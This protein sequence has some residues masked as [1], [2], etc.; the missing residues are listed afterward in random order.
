M[1]RSERHHLKENEISGIVNQTVAQI[2]EHKARFGMVA[3]IVALVAVAG[4]GY[5][6]W[7]TRSETRAHTMFGE[8]LGIFQAP[9]QA[10][11]A[12]T[13]GAT[14]VQA[15][16]TYPTLNARAE[17]VLPKFM[18][19]ADA[20]PSS[21][22]GIAARY[23]AASALS[24]L[25]RGADAAARFKDVEDRAGAD[26]FFGKMARLGTIDAQVL[27][28]Q[29]D[30]AIT[31]AQALVSVTDD[32]YPRDAMLMQLGRIYAAAG[33]T[34]Q[35]KETFNKVLSDFPE[36]LYADEAHQQIDA[37]AKS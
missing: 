13:E 12:P 28:K 4:G 22:S 21:A 30:Q 8:A 10:P 20:Y 33:K 31:G 23:Y 25:G 3:G 19:V 16:G 1:K 15:P 37:L 9:V 14:P 11:A 17:A 6:A 36:S 7:H 35:A 34:S 2:S 32:A 5:W 26:S 29:Y 27:A 24:L 18:E